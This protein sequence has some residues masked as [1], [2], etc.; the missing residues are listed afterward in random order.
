MVDSGGVPVPERKRGK[1]A[2]V[3]VII[4]VL[5]IAVGLIYLY[6]PYNPSGPV[7]PGPGE[8]Q[9][10]TEEQIELI[11]SNNYPHMRE[12]LLNSSD[13]LTVCLASTENNITICNILGKNDDIKQCKQN[14]NLILSYQ[15]KCGEL[16][17]IEDSLI[18]SESLFCE[19]LNS[20]SCDGLT[21]N[22]ELFCRYLLGE[23][24]DLCL[25][26]GGN[27]QGCTD[28]LNLYNSL[29]ETDATYCNKMTYSYNKILCNSLL[30]GSCS[31]SIDRV[32][33]DWVYLQLSGET[34]DLSICNEIIY[35]F[36]KGPC[37]AGIGFEDIF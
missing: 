15:N 3:F 14:Y 12:I 26:A 28:Y 31:E 9:T 1:R 17:I 2:P 8:N 33:K 10:Y 37:M 6:Y 30:A 5:I 36:I 7:I 27:Y 29:K 25:N 20:L 4:V 23:D 24:M 34:S 16:L 22:T 19:K 13:A 18:D 21:G 32:A 35:D 11:V